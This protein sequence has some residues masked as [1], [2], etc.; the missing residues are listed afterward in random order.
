MIDDGFIGT[1]EI[2][3]KDGELDIGWFAF[4]QST[5]EVKVGYGLR[6]YKS[7]IALFE[8]FSNYRRHR[9]NPNVR[10]GLAR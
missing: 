10:V 1:L 3:Y 8:Q 7:I 4:Y 9:K 5:S 6:V 2:S